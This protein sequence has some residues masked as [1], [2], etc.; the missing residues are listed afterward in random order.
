MNAV[1]LSSPQQINLFN[2]ALLAR[3]EQFSPRQLLAWIAFAVVALVAVAWWATSQMRLLRSEIAEQ[4]A[5][6]KVHPGDSAPS[7]QQIAALEQALRA[8]VATLE[9]RQA[10]L[11]TLKRGMAGAESGPSFVLRRLAETIPPTA[12]LVEVRVGANRVDLRGRAL[13]P[14]AVDAWLVRLRSS[15]FIAEKPAPTLRVDRMEPAAGRS[16]EAYAF[17]LTGALGAPFADEGARP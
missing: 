11:A 8:R 1:V 4:G 9:A 15:G 6:A 12:W 14:G 13:E 5:R 10:A 3:R 2:A 17:E 16:G 7:P